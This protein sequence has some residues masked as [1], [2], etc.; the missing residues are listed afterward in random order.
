[1]INQEAYNDRSEKLIAEFAEAGWPMEF[2]K[3]INEEWAFI[4]LTPASEPTLPTLTPYAL[5]Q[6]KN[7]FA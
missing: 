6:E 1:V 2:D 5:T 4:R 7:R 3:E